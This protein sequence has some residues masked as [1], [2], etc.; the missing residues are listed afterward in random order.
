MERV[1]EMNGNNS[2]EEIDEEGDKG[3]GHVSIP[4]VRRE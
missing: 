1:T 2:D 4:G 3:M